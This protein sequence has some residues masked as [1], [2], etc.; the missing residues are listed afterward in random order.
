MMLILEKL[1]EECMGT[2]HLCS[3][4]INLN[5]FQSKM[6]SFKKSLGF[7]SLQES[8]PKYLTTSQWNTSIG[9]ISQINT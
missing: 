4:P 7:E 3:F 8:L 9:R 1:G 6:A 2:L 5:L